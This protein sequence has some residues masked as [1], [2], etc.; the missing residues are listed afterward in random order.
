M[1]LA[2]GTRLQDF[3]TG[4]WALFKNPDRRIIGLNVQ[5]FDATKHHA[6][7]LVADARVGLEELEPRAAAAGRRRTPGPRKARRSK[8]RWFDEPRALHAIRPMRNC[9]PTRR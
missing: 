2:V 5:T 4:S 1:V 9:P 3:T 8:A 6:L 7:P